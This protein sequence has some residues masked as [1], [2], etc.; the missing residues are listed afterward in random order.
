MKKFYL[1]II[2]VFV[3]NIYSQENGIAFLNIPTDVKN[4]AMGNVT[5]VSNESAASLFSNPA[6][7]AKVNTLNLY[8]SGRFGF[9]ES[10]FG[11]GAFIWKTRNY[12]AFGFGFINLGIDEIQKR[13]NL[14]HFLGNMQSTQTAFYLSYAR[15]FL[16]DYSVGINIKYA[17][18]NLNMMDESAK[19]DG[20][21]VELGL[22][23]SLNKNWK[24][25]AFLRDNMSIKWGENHINES[26]ITLKLGSQYSPDIFDGFLVK[27]EI[28]QRQKLPMFFNAG[29]EYNISPNAF[30]SGIALRVGISNIYLE[31]RGLSVS[32]SKLIENNISYST[33]FGIVTS[34]G[35][36]EFAFDY[37]FRTHAYLDNMHFTGITLGF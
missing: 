30:I 1:I 37:A 32:T 4:A 20:F 3:V 19:A 7:L 10:D 13:D 21:G 8:A 18:I 15:S 23:Y 33:G 14:N 2:L 34:V 28:V 26:P 27:L 35:S 16:T 22:L 25:G 24:F 12:G 11:V 36:L 5:S 31:S 17:S 9:M 29:M 6:S